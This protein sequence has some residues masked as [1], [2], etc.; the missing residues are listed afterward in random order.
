MGMT[1]GRGSYMSPDL[2]IVDCRSLS[3]SFGKREPAS[4]GKHGHG[5]FSAARESSKVGA[6]SIS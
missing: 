2:V 4:P 5:R 1:T 6:Y 3:H